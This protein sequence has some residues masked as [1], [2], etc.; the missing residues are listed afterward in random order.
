MT[1]HKNKEI[2]YF[3]I[4]CEIAD[5]K[6]TTSELEETGYMDVEIIFQTLKYLNY[7]KRDKKYVSKNGVYRK[8][9]HVNGPDDPAFTPLYKALDL[10]DYNSANF[11][12]N[13]YNHKRNILIN[14]R[15]ILRFE[16]PLKR[17]II[18]KKFAKNKETTEYNHYLTQEYIKNHQDLDN[19]IL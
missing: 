5:I 3:E 11:C 8:K 16:E 17:E 12:F 9:Y 13:G 2:T 1:K 10:N 7:D 14:K 18:L 4:L 15:L 6:I 19:S